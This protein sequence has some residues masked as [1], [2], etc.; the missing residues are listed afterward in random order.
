MSQNIHW[1]GHRSVLV[2]LG[3]VLAAC[4]NNTTT[5][6]SPPKIGGIKG[7]ATLGGNTS[8]NGGI[9]V[10]VQGGSAAL[11]DDAGDYLISGVAP[12]K[13]TVS[14][15]YS[16]YVT[17]TA[18]VTVAA[19]QVST[20]AEI[21]LSPTPAAPPT[22]GAVKG[23]ATLNGKRTG[24]TGIIVGT[25]G[26]PSALSDD[27]G[28][29]TI[30]GLAPG[31]Y[32]L[33]AALATAVDNAEA[34]NLAKLRDTLLLAYGASGQ[35]LDFIANQ[36]EQT[37]ELDMNTDTCAKTTRVSQ[38]LDTLQGFIFAVRNGEYLGSNSLTI[39]SGDPNDPNNLTTFDEE[40]NWMGRTR[41][42]ARPSSCSCIPRI[43]SIR[44]F[45]PWSDRRLFFA[46]SP[47]GFAP[48]RA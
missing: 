39:V 13:Y 47:T 31:A 34:A 21:D 22:T 46:L 25:P 23:I 32:T 19:G 8:G 12:G 4:S 15:A 6:L 3:L 41:H 24:D 37:V 28:N 14:A 33:A 40:W 30:T 45:V 44:P 11:T 2:V 17:A 38:A 7:I 16:G 48:T 26:G 35:S 18:Q 10:G 42:G 20:L 36:V 1:R 9:V 27:A 43:F 5:M 29:Y